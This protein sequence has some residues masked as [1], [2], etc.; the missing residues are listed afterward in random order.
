MRLTKILAIRKVKKMLW[1]LQ[2]P[3]YKA[4]TGKFIFQ[5]LASCLTYAFCAFAIMDDIHSIER[6][7]GREGRVI[8][9]LLSEGKEFCIVQKYHFRLVSTQVCIQQVL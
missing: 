2:T 6:N 1:F 3:F 4:P 9:I 8:S 5:W 7:N